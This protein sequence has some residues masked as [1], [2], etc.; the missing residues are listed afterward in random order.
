MYWNIVLDRGIVLY[1]FVKYNIEQLEERREQMKKYL[2]ARNERNEK[3]RTNLRKLLV[4]TLVDVVV[5][6]DPQVLN[7]FLISL[8]VSL[9]EY[10]H[11]F[12]KKNRKW[13][14]NAFVFRLNKFERFLTLYVNLQGLI[15]FRWEVR[16][17]GWELGE[18]T[19]GFSGHFNVVLLR[20]QRYFLSISVLT[21]PFLP[22]PSSFS[23]AHLTSLI[24]ISASSCIPASI[25]FPAPPWL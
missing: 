20:L 16:I 25:G 17:T 9:Q 14:K 15:R 5:L 2:S 11:I 1:T 10:C 18:M 6:K 13:I 19:P 8:M 12:L 3:Q 24:T 21:Q 22:N 7:H 23:P 4:L